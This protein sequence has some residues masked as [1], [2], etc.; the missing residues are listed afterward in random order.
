MERFPSFSVVSGD[1]TVDYA[2]TKVGA[3]LEPLAGMTHPVLNRHSPI[4]LYR[5]FKLENPD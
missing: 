2:P 4:E 1:L 5:L 3:S